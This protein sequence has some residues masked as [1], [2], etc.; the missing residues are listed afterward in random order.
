MAAV[1]TIEVDQDGR[2]V[3]FQRAP[4]GFIECWNDEEDRPD[5]MAVWLPPGETPDTLGLTTFIAADVPA[6][7]DFQEFDD[8]EGE[9]HEDCP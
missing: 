2:W 4:D 5:T 8:V 9:T 3:D 6:E 1:L 7:D